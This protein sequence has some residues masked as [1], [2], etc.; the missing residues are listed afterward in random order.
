MLELGNAELESMD[1]PFSTASSIFVVL[2]LLQITV[3]TYTYHKCPD[4]TDPEASV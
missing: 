1:L 2:S 3:S 4:H